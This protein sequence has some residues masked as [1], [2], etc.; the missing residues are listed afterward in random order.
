MFILKKFHF[1]VILLLFLFLIPNIIF[2]EQASN[3][4]HINNSASRPAEWIKVDDGLYEFQ[5]TSNISK[6][7]EN[8]K[9]ESFSKKLSQ[10]RKNHSDEQIVG[11]Q[12]LFSGDSSSSVTGY[13]LTTEKKATNI[14]LIATIISGAVT[15]SIGIFTL[16]SNLYTN[17]KNLFVN[18][19]TAE[20]VKW[21][22]ELREHVSEFL[23]LVTYHNEKNKSTDQKDKSEYIDNVLRLSAKIKLHLNYLD[24]KDQKIIKI[25]NEL[26]NDIRKIFETNSLISSLTN[27]EYINML[28]E[29]KESEIGKEIEK[30]HKKFPKMYNRPLDTNDMERIDKIVRTQYEGLVLEE[31]NIENE[32]LSKRMHN[33]PQKLLSLTQAYLKD[34]WNRVKAEAEVGNITKK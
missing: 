17:K 6:K 29:P 3:S 31:I 27:D 26:T 10:F 13:I 9:A 11:L 8:E 21:M 2:A 20:R 23:T 28:L 25:V 1:G 16:L 30:Q 18:T 19:I 34:E 4:K 32:A 7:S 33:N 14:T 24:R 5:F 12:P 22:G 15:A